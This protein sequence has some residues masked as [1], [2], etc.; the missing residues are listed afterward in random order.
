M[1][2][3]IR[4]QS[5]RYFSSVFTMALHRHVINTGNIL[6]KDRSNV[7]RRHH[8]YHRAAIDVVMAAL[9]FSYALFFCSAATMRLCWCNFNFNNEGKNEHKAHDMHT[10]CV[11][12]LHS[13]RT[14]GASHILAANRMI[15]KVP[16]FMD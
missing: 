1:E 8:Y 5:F 9:Q 4:M 12:I 15:P 11:P 7:C 10:V 14:N 13:S 16:H 2:D 6:C 3:G